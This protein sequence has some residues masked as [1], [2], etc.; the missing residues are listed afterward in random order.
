MLLVG[1]PTLNS[2]TDGSSRANTAAALYDSTYE[3]LLTTNRWRFAHARLVLSKLVTAPLH[4]YSNAF[5]LPSDYLM[6]ES[7]YPRGD[8]EIYGDKLY[9]NL[10]S[11]TL[12]YLSKP[13]ETKLPAYFQKVLEYRLAVELCIPI[14]EN[15]ALKAEL[16]AD[17]IGSLQAAMWADAQGRPPTSVIDSPLVDVR[18]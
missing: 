15:R 9:S 5:Q 16:K 8:Y 12:D 18:F 1:S 6:A 7:V 3:S 17:Y 4:T 10:D 11:V 14:T 13:V 2:L